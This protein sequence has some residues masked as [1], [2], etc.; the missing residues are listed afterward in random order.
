V[1]DGLDVEALSRQY[2]AM[3]LRRCRRL[4]GDPRTL[5]QALAEIDR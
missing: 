3:V 4:L 2:G 5:R 1:N